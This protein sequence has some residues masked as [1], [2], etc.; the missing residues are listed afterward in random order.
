MA[1]KRITPTTV[2][3]TAWL[4]RGRHTGP[5]PEQDVRRNLIALKAAGVLEDFLDLDPV[6]AARSTPL[7][8]RDGSCDAG[9]SARRVFEA[10]WRT[11]GD[12]TVRAQLTTY[13][14]EARRGREQGGVLWV[15]AAESERVWDVSGPSPL[16][17]FWPDSEQVAWDGD[18][19]PGVR[20]RSVN[21]LPRDDDELRQRLRDCTRDSWS[22]H[23]VV[24]EAMT[25]GPRGRRPVAEFL[26]PGL[27]HRIVEHRAA[28]EQ[29]QI[30][31]FAL[32]R[33]LGVRLPRG[34]AV[35][36]PPDHQ[37]LPADVERLTV[38]NVFLDGSEPVELLHRVSEFAGLLRTL[39]A[40]A[41]QALTRLRGGWRLLTPDEELAHAKAMVTRYAEELEAM[42]RSRD[43]YQE[44]AE[45][46]RDALAEH[47]ALRDAPWPPAPRTSATES[48]S[49]LSGITKVFGRFREPN[50]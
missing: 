43:L 22:V 33:E 25:P 11:T 23:L 6:D 36:L 24:H 14:A 44:A 26:P 48:T 21:D 7:H 20:L 28:P 30:A 10:R 35:V 38:R 41:E 13:D 47:S 19:V 1:K 46:A 2:P 31:D 49:P 32:K 50:S 5:E 40:D 18:A 9:P 12:V 16:T 29:A 39:P 34:G 4:G 27:R 37:D 15:L 17:M 3:D 45:A 8:P 42:T